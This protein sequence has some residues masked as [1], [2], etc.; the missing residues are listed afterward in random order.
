[1]TTHLS[2]WGFFHPLCRGRN[3][4]IRVTWVCFAEVFPVAYIVICKC[5]C[6]WKNMLCIWNKRGSG[7]S[8]VFIR[9]SGLV[10]GKALKLLSPQWVL[11]LLRSLHCVTVDH[12]PFSGNLSILVPGHEMPYVFVILRGA[13]A[14]IRNLVGCACDSVSCRGSDLLCS[15][16]NEVLQGLLARV[17]PISGVKVSTDMNNHRHIVNL[18]AWQGVLGTTGVGMDVAMREFP[19][20]EECRS[21]P[22]AWTELADRSSID[23]LF[24][25]VTSHVETALTAKNKK[26][27]LF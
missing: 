12:V 5:I 1:M 15:R 16:L 24:P 7:T 10:L 2:F 8:Q 18:S 22:A 14:E 11:I 17:C 13:G 19:S 9:S 23:F 21:A 4:H 27:I 6:K 25:Y 3:M 26:C 20:C